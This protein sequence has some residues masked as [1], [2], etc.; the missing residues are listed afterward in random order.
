VDLNGWTIRD[1]N[2]DF[3]VISKSVILNPGNYIILGNNSDYNS[4]GSVTVHYQYENFELH[5]VNDEIEILSPSGELMDKVSYEEGAIFPLQQGYSFALK[6]PNMENNFGLHWNASNVQIGEGDFGT[7]G[8]SNI[9]EVQ[10]LSIKDI[11]YTED[12]SGV[13][14]LLNQIVTISGV[15]TTDPLGFFN[16]WF[17]IQDS[18][19]KWSGIAVRKHTTSLERGDSIKISGLVV[20][21]SGDITEI[22]N[23]YDYEILK[24]GVFGI[25]PVHVTTGEVNNEGE[26]AEAY[27]GMLIKVSG[28]CDNDSLNG[29]EWG[30]ND[31]TG[32]TRVSSVYLT[33]FAP[34]IGMDYEVTGIQYYGGGNFKIIPWGNADVVTGIENENK[35]LPMEYRLYHN[36]PNPFNPS[37]TIMYSI[38]E[39]GIVSLKIFDMLGSEAA[40]L[41]NKQQPPGNYKIKWDA[42]GFASG[43]YFYKLTSGSFIEIKKMILLR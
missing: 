18:M 40:I 23:T 29:L 32:Q 16:Q 9:P 12:P 5:D 19:D 36:Y 15:V 28:I 8:Y 37:T 30:I 38:P 35:S 3:H 31:G 33:D 11:Q 34:A 20:E 25:S 14:P 42:S 39:K 2:N 21:R 26:N 24:K 1:D 10:S 22:V 17:Y 4:N 7:P 13:S 43:I 41:V 6:E 27:E